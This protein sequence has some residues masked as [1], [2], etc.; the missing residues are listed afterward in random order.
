MFAPTPA[1]VARAGA[2]SADVGSVSGFTA[3]P[4]A[5]GVRTSNG[6]RVGDITFEGTLGL[7]LFVGI[8]SG[9]VGGVVFA[10]VEPWLRRL[11]PWHG[12][13]FGLAL[14]ATFGFAV[15]DPSN[16]DFRRFGFAAL[17]IAMFAALFLA[18]GVLIAWVFDRLRATMEGPA[19]QRGLPRSP[20]G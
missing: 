6:N 19:S 3:G 20:P 13:V 12:L 18:F 2:R 14:L 7:V 10:A 5:V 1:A 8:V 9:L 4:E 11:R 15:L 17:N 16:F